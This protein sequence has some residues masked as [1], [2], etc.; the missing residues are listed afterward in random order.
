MGILQLQVS[1]QIFNVAN[2]QAKPRYEA[3]TV[4]STCSTQL[5]VLEENSAEDRH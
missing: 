3:F 1:D 5:H 4:L 2:L